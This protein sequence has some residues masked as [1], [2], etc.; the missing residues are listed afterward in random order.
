MIT[1]GT[2]TLGI[3]QT[4]VYGFDLND[5][6]N[7]PGGGTT[8]ISGTPTVNGVNCTVTYVSAS[9]GIASVKAVAASGL[10]AGAKG[11]VQLTTTFANGEILPAKIEL[12][13]V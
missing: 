1:V 3:G 11:E 12:V 10:G 5:Y 6:L 9:A 13:F 8:T 2:D 7:L 4:K